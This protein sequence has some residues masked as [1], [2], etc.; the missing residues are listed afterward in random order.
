MPAQ[1]MISSTRPTGADSINGGA[2]TDFVSYFYSQKAVTIDLLAGKADGGFAK[3]D[4][5]IGVEGIEGSTFGDFITG[6]NEANILRGGKGGDY[7]DG[8]DGIDTADYTDLGCQGRGRSRGPAR[9]PAAMRTATS[10][11][12][13]R[14]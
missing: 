10:S 8:G 9:R 5:F 7:L 6:D 12:P 3:G 1:A 2:G 14:M 4:S 13:S 11:S